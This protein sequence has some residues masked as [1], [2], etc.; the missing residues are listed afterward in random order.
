MTEQLW[1]EDGAWSPEPDQ[2][3]VGSGGHSYSRPPEELDDDE[4]DGPE[5]RV[6]VVA[7]DHSQLAPPGF[8]MDGRRSMSAILVEM[9]AVVAS[10]IPICIADD[11]YDFRIDLA[12]A[13]WN[14]AIGKT[15]RYDS[16]MESSRKMDEKK[17]GFHDSNIALAHLQ[18]ML[19]Y[20][21]RRYPA[22]RR[23]ILHVRIIEGDHIQVIWEEE[24]A[25]EPRPGQ[26]RF[27]NFDQWQLERRED[28][29]LPK[30]RREQ[31]IRLGLPREESVAAALRRRLR[32]KPSLR[33]RLQI[34]AETNCRD[35]DAMVAA[36]RASVSW[37]CDRLS[38]LWIGTHN[39]IGEFMLATLSCDA[40][41]DIT[42]FLHHRIV[43]CEYPDTDFLEPTD[44]HFS[45]WAMHDHRVGPD[46]ETW[47][48]V[49]LRLCEVLGIR[50]HFTEWAQQLTSLS[51]GVYVHEGWSTQG[52][53]LRDFVTE[54][55]HTVQIWPRNRYRGRRGDLWHTRVLP[56]ILAD[57][58]AGIT[59]GPPYV[60]LNDREAPVD[61][62][63]RY[64]QARLSDAAGDSATAYRRHM[65][66]GRSPGYWIDFL[67]DRFSH[68]E[69]DIGFL[70]G[71][72]ELAKR[73]AAG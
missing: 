17:P 9:A 29:Y 51:P 3:S 54:E 44:L 8:T 53:R 45:Q 2:R 59:M 58:G 60:L 11:S 25:P 50:N 35:V 52:I 67:H 31:R 4:E 37:E 10:D 6:R 19:A 55:E 27:G 28:L 20:R 7:I 21:Q 18:I 39:R 65:K 26:P 73:T 1:D 49:A 69:N 42:D 68:R 63:R 14:R 12:H 23:E 70:N 72:P 61:A 62:W 66:F 15:E 13:A 48:Q 30:T 47:G 38:G 33:D 41:E 24:D 43:R 22:D 36:T 32:T 56:N 16:I 64:F 46:D 5:E 71:L 34:L 40:V 57:G